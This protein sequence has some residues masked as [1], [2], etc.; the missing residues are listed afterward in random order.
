[1]YGD[2]GFW[3]GYAVWMQE[4]RYL[5]NGLALGIGGK[6]GVAPGHVRRGVSGKFANGIER[7]APNGEP[8]AE[9]VPQGMKDDFLGGVRNAVVQPHCIYDFFEGADSYVAG[10]GS[11]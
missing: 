6:L 5:L 7:H 10:Y 2:Y 1:M 4:G 8:G 9:S 3:G 11:A